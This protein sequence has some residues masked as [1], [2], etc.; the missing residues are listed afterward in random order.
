MNENNENPSVLSLFVY[1]GV[2]VSDDPVS[3]WW[4]T[5]FAVNGIL[6]ELHKSLI[7]TSHV[8][9]NEGQRRLLCSNGVSSRCPSFGVTEESVDEAIDRLS[10]ILIDAFLESKKYE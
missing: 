8:V 3:L 2:R 1:D 4:K 10:N 9:P 6:K 5:F 7:D